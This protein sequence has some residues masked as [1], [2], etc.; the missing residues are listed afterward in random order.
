VRVLQ[1]DLGAPH[2]RPKLSAIQLAAPCITDLDL[3]T[4]PSDRGV[5][6]ARQWFHYAA[7]AFRGWERLE[8]LTITLPQLSPEICPAIG[9]LPRLRYLTL[10]SPGNFHEPVQERPFAESC[11]HSVKELVSEISAEGLESVVAH[12]GVVTGLESFTWRIHSMR[13]A[14]SPSTDV[15]FEALRQAQ[16][17]RRLKIVAP[18]KRK[19]YGI[20]FLDNPVRRLACLSS[21]PL[22]ELDLTGIVMPAD[23]HRTLLDSWPDLVRLNLDNNELPIDALAGIAQ[24][25]PRLRFLHLAILDR[26]LASLLNLPLIV[27]HI[28]ITDQA[29]EVCLTLTL[30]AD[31]GDRLAVK[32]LAR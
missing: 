31:Q 19:T 9:G 14:S 23:F 21:V 24:S 29:V 7:Q 10:V 6:G 4:R 28:L 30:P 1:L 25:H 5:E 11:F 13:C 8:R 20:S 18:I 2:Y 15:V 27:E 17:L 26:D 3:R 22:R 16:A 32:R 12:S